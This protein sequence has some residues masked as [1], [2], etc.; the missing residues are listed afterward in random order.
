MLDHESTCDAPSR[1][2]KA[3][4]QNQIGASAPNIENHKVT[5]SLTGTGEELGSSLCVIG[6]HSEGLAQTVSVL[7]NSNATESEH[8]HSEDPHISSTAP[9]SSHPRHYPNSDHNFL[10]ETRSNIY[11][12]LPPVGVTTTS[13]TCSHRQAASSKDL[14]DDILMLPCLPRGR[15]RNRSTRK[16]FNSVTEICQTAGATSFSEKAV[17]RHNSAPYQLGSSHGRRGREMPDDC[18]PTD[19]K[20]RDQ[21]AKEGQRMR[22]LGTGWNQDEERL[23]SRSGRLNPAHHEKAKFLPSSF[24]DLDM[25]KEVAFQQVAVEMQSGNETWPSLDCE[26]ST[27]SFRADVN[28]ASISDNHDASPKRPFTNHIYHQRSPPT[29]PKPRKRPYR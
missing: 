24:L 28:M 13:P 7:I 4:L 5:N 27:G 3:A 2:S 25:K 20:Q 6:Q 9:P 29:C 8:V 12:A 23:H 21:H 26:Q 15:L 11:Q 22:M 10:V 1:A 17:D 14:L 18:L 16:T 19:F